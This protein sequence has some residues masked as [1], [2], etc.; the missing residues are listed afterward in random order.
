LVIT[1][2]GNKA[3]SSVPIVKILKGVLALMIM[4]MAVG[5]YHRLD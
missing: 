2:I 5:P 1:T 4:I 3:Q